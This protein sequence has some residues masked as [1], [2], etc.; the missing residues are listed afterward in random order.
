MP[1]GDK[2]DGRSGDKQDGRSRVQDIKAYKECPLWENMKKKKEAERYGSCV[3][4]DEAE[5]LDDT[6]TQDLFKP[7]PEFKSMGQL[8]IEEED[9]KCLGELKHDVCKQVTDDMLKECDKINPHGVKLRTESG[10][11]WYEEDKDEY[12]D[13]V[14]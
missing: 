11:Q 13:K 2:Q 8:I 1:N 4:I 10:F 6:L 5:V 7:N 14:M 12:P 3:T 9:A